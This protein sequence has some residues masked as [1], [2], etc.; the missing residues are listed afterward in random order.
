M[1]GQYGQ[2]DRRPVSWCYHLDQQRDWCVPLNKP[3]SC[4][5]CERYLDML[6]ALD[7]WE[8]HP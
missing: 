2:S 7:R 5:G 1:T 3:A 6:V 4:K 8:A